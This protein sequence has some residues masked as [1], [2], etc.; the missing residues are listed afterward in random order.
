MV[1]IYLGQMGVHQ[2]EMGFPFSSHERNY[3]AANLEL[4]Q[5]GVMGKMILS[6]WLRA[7]KGDMLESLRTGLV[8][9]DL[10]M[11]T[12]PQM[13]ANK[14]KGKLTPRRSSRRWR[15]R[16]RRHAERR[17]LHHRQR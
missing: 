5:I 8:D 12:S 6:G 1:N 16:A 14:F 10:S 15:M 7:Q 4:A 11:S 17:P 3:I 9:F 2:S 13:M